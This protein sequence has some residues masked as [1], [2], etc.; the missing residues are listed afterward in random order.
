MFSTKHPADL[1]G[2]H[3]N[4]NTPGGVKPVTSHSDDVSKPMQIKEK[5]LG[6]RPLGSALAGEGDLCKRDSL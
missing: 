2:F 5:M 1:P 6:S 4:L 3:H